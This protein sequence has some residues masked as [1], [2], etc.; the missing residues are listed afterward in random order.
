LAGV[1][2][3]RCLRRGIRRCLGRRDG[4]EAIQV[5]PIRTPS[6][7]GEAFCPC[8]CCFGVRHCR[9]FTCGKKAANEGKPRAAAHSPDG[10]QTRGT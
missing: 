10:D 8:S 9:K 5:K 4:G 6:P 2:R 1:D 3:C 7:A